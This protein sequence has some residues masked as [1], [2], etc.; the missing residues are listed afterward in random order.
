MIKIND[1]AI[2]LIKSFEGFFP[3]AYHGAKDKPGIDTIGYGTIRY[4]S[5]YLGGKKVKIGD[6]KITEKQAFDFLK[7]EVDKVL[8]QIDDLMRDDLT[9]NQFG[10][11]TS[12]C[13]NL[14]VGSLKMSH[15]REKVNANPNDPAIR[16]EFMKWTCS[17][18]ECGILGLVRRRKAEANLYFKK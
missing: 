2:N 16:D 13:Y 15:L 9:E 17:N 11:L 12:F 4:P 10:A 7:Y 3:N 6:P 8:P 1:D 14:G 5:Y 18:G